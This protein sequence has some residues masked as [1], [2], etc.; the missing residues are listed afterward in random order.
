MFMRTILTSVFLWISEIFLNRRPF[1]YNHRG[2]EI[3]VV[4]PYQLF[5]EHPAIRSG[6]PVFLLEDPLFFG[7]D[8]EQPL[9]FHAKKLMLHRASMKRYAAGFED[10]NYVELPKE[11]CRSDELLEKVVPEEVRKISCVDPTDYLLERRLRRFARRE[12]SSCRC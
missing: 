8:S 12:G 1:F 3:S 11:P 2:M 5:A 7:T 4:Y 6:K 9:K 10:I